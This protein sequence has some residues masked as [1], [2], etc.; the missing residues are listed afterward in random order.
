ML[1]P[2]LVEPIGLKQFMSSPVIRVETNATHQTLRIQPGEVS[3]QGKIRIPGDKCWGR[4]PR[5]KP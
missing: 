1:L 5:E 2:I 3:L 4:S